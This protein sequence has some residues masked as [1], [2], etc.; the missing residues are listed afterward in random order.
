M[1][2]H[3][4]N[5]CSQLGGVQMLDDFKCDRSV[6]TQE[7]RVAVCKDPFP[8]FNVPGATRP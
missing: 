4:T 1:V 7:H 2:E 3:D 8:Q 6:V 5:K